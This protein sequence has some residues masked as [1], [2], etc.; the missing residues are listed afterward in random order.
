MQALQRNPNLKDLAE[1]L[2]WAKRTV[3]G[4]WRQSP[5]GKTAFV[6]YKVGALN[7]ETM[8]PVEWAAL[9][10][11]DPTLEQDW[12]R[13]AVDGGIRHR[14]FE[15][16]ERQGRGPLVVVRDESGSMSGPQHALAVALEWALLEIA[17]R[18]RRDF[19][20]I[21]FS[22]RGQYHVWKAPR[23]GSPDPQ[24]LLDHLAH[25]YGGGTDPYPPMVEAMRLIAVDDLRAD[26]LVITDAAF[27][28]APPEFLEGLAKVRAARPLRIETVVVGANGG[29][30][31][32][33]SDRVTGVGNLVRDRDQVKTA[34]SGVV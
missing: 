31:D 27:P 7:P 28:K 18:D 32:E 14:H 21:P 13:R 34:I 23:P 30:A 3:R 24:G 6:G 17:Q 16:T 2:G 11:G 8:A 5:R 22:G 20:S 15:G 33:W 12:I 29:A 1:M 19:Y 10:G 4:E 25:F 26:V 9:L